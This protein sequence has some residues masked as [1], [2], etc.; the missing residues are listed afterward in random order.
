MPGGMPHDLPLVSTIAVGLAYALVGGFLAVRVGLPPLVGYLLAG[1]AVGPFTPGFVADA[2]LT[3]E[4]AEIGVMLLMF[5]VGMHFSLG[6][7]LAVRAVA[8][9]G[10]IFQMLFATA[11]SMGVC[12]FWGWSWGEGL[13]FGISLSVA[14]TVVLLRALESLNLLD[15]RAG[16]IAVGWLIVE[17]LLT[18][19]I[20]VLLPIFAE[21]LGGHAPEGHGAASG[22]ALWNI[23]IT[24]G[25]TAVF[26]ALMLTL[27]KR[28]F[29]WLIAQIVRT[30]S[31]ELFT[32]AVTALALGVAYAAAVLFGVSFALGSFFAGMVIRE[33]DSS[34]RAAKDLQTIQDAFSALFFVSIGMLF[35]PM[36]L[37]RHPLHILETVAIIVLGK[38]FIAFG[39]AVLFRAQRSTAIT[40]SAALAQ[41]GEFSF[42]LAALGLQLGILKPEGQHL[43]LAGALISI[44]LNPLI[45]RAV[46]RKTPREEPVAA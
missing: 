25:K 35:D 24:L 28:V 46:A 19:L 34:H 30:G 3:H 2:E 11:L 37:I 20:L 16:R 39:V 44:T 14:S 8:L 45:F 5:G 26:V 23:T 36:S 10:A 38:S 27:G 21:S 7:L 17:D 40:V 15:T 43:I 13:V 42:I 41:I 29:S 33:S 32:L 31:R 9:P 12:H 18:V 4:L 6:D 1:I 22:G